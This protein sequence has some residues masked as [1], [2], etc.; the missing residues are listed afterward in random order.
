MISSKTSA[1]LSDGS[2]SNVGRSAVLQATSA[3]IVVLFV[4]ALLPP[5]YF[6]IGSTRLSL[7]RIL[8]LSLIVPLLIRLISGQAGRL[9]MTDYLIFFYCSWIALTYTYHYGTARIA[10]SGIT[11]I[12]Q[13][14]AYLVGRTLIRSAT[15]YKIFVRTFFVALLV[16]FPFALFELFTGRNLWAMLFDPIFSIHQKPRSAYGRMGLERVMSGFEHPILYGLF[17][18]LGMANFFYVYQPK[19][20]KAAAMTIFTVTMTFMSLSSAPLMAVASQALMIIWDKATK[21]RWVLLAC[22]V[23]L[24]YVTVDTLSNRTPVTILISTLTF[25]P[26][27]AWTRIAIWDY[28]SAAVL[29]NPIMGIGLEDWPRAAWVTSSVDNFWLL[30]SMR[31][32]LPAIMLLLGGLVFHLAAILGVKNLSPELTRYRTGY[33]LALLCVYF[34]LC[35]VHIWG[36]MSSFVFFYI[37]AGLWFVNAAGQGSEAAPGHADS[38]QDIAQPHKAAALARRRIEPA[39]GTTN[40]ATGL[41]SSRFPIAH[42]REQS[43]D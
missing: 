38:H 19:I 3:L 35:T 20:F 6:N 25:N 16:L 14:G 2:A 36:G 40:R 8:L 17:C 22:L 21:G 42:K 32:G 24:A 41:P 4:L 27:T 18:S 37:G 43:E 29:A 28:G 33:V 30:I 12:E 9:M 10:L 15:D 34:T 1:L 26:G 31:H 39:L 7:S 11:I 23:V 13:L 5:V